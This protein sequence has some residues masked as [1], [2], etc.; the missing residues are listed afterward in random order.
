MQYLAAAVVATL[1]KVHVRPNDRVLIM[2]PNGPGFAEAFAGAIQQ[3][4][5]PL[6]ASP[7]SAHEIVVIVCRG[8]AR[9]VPVP[10]DRIPA[11]AG[12]GAMPLSWTEK[13]ISML[14]ITAVHR[15]KRRS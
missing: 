3:G 13:S 12:L 10:A 5:V 8:G 9:L 6:P 15:V 7:L 14:D 4:A 2:L 1:T 11:L